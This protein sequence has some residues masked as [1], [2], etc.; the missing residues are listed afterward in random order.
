MSGRENKL[1]GKILSVNISKVKGV[2]KTP[3]EEI[4]LIEN[5]G[6]KDDAH[7]GNWH[8]QVSML[9]VSSIE[10]AR[11]WG[12][13]ANYGDF[14]ENITVD[15]VDVYRL[16][17]GTKVYINDLVEL[18]VTQIGKECH[19]RCAIAKTVGK[20]VMPV[21]GIFLKVLKGGKAKAGDKVVFI[22]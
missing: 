19:D 2:K 15:G 12:I 14:A 22:L 18:E 9:S 3:A 13:E 21:E 10:K 6:V 5:Y 16:P 20:C 4:E 8:R 1:E 7:A 17:V 11:N